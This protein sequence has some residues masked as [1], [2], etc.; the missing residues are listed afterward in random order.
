MYMYIRE[1]E[2]RERERAERESAMN[3][4]SLIL[5]CLMILIKF[6]R[7][8]AESINHELKTLALGST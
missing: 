7:D 5:L 8:N 4:M 1:R 3:V 6:K 2:S